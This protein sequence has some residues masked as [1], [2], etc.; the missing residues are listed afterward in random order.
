MP[1]S[2]KN[3]DRSAGADVENIPVQL[4]LARPFENVVDLSRFSMVMPD[5]IENLGNVKRAA[6]A[7]GRGDNSRAL[8]TGAGDGW[9]RF[10]LP[11]NVACCLH[12]RDRAW[13]P[14]GT[15]FSQHRRVLPAKEAR[16]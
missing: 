10:G 9:G 5:G 11:N 1:G 14:L 7:V 15:Y 12:H 3:R 2:W 4:H 13:V 6:D 16:N 8:P